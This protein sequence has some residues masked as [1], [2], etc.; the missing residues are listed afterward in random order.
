MIEHNDQ[1]VPKKIPGY[2]MTK[3]GNTAESKWVI[4][5]LFIFFSRKCLD[6]CVNRITPYILCFCSKPSSIRCTMEFT[7]QRKFFFCLSYVAR[8]LSIKDPLGSKA[9]SQLHFQRNEKCGHFR[10]RRVRVR[11]LLPSYS[12]PF[13]KLYFPKVGNYTLICSSPS[14]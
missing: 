4:I 12:Y 14:S 13:T 9:F 1:N 8:V 7:V 10:R 11:R 3:V 6:H 5:V 2:Q